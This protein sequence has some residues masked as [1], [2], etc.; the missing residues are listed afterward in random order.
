MAGFLLFP[1]NHFLA[2]QSNTNS[3]HDTLIIFTCGGSVFAS[4]LSCI[5]LHTLLKSA[6]IIISFPK[7]QNCVPPILW[8]LD[9]KFTY[10]LSRNIQKWVLA[11]C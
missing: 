3:P 9:F 7:S 2:R 4:S 8:L 6:S 5:G 1:Q 11:E 10:G